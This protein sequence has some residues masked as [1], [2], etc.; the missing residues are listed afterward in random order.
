MSEERKFNGNVEESAQSM[1][2]ET[3]EQTQQPFD[4]NSA[5]VEEWKAVLEEREAEIAGLKDKLLRQTAEMENTRKRL[6]RERTEAI[7]F[8]NEN[9]LRELLAVV[10]NL[11]RAIQHAEQDADTQQLLE[12]VKMTHKHFLDT[13]ARFGCKPFE[14]EGKDFD[15]CYHEAIVQHET[16][17]HPA[18]SV[19]QEFQKGYMLHDRLLRPAMVAV[20]KGSR[21]SGPEEVPR[22]ESAADTQDTTR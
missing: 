21:T 8:A 1:N 22:E 3:Q 17:E 10:D 18:N 12:G 6:E 5:T 14:S 2:G 16:E 9:L 15:P 19:V 11:E 13:L 20:A 7:T 4:P